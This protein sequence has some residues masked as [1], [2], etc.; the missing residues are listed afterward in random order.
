MNVCI[1]L[2]ASRYVCMHPYI[3]AC[4]Y[5]YIYLCMHVDIYIYIYIQEDNSRSF[6]TFIFS[7]ETV[8]AEGVVIGRV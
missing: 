4:M 8:R 6:H 5:V 7:R 2:C 1:Y 3:C